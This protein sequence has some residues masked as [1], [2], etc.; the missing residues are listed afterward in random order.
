MS[1]KYDQGSLLFGQL[2]DESWVQSKVPDVSLVA[3]V[4]EY[5]AMFPV[6]VLL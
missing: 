2:S 5:R 3:G 4:E 1:S 6:P